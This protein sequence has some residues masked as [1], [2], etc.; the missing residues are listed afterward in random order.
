MQMHACVR[1]QNSWKKQGRGSDGVRKMLNRSWESSRNLENRQ[2]EKCSSVPLFPQQGHR[3]KTERISGVTYRE[4]LFVGLHCT[5]MCM[6]SCISLR[7]FWRPNVRFPPCLK[8]LTSDGKWS[9]CKVKQA[10]G[11]NSSAHSSSPA[12]QTGSD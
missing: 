12:N 2:R 8:P 7:P 5:R 9:R 11:F 4:H 6:C 10:S 3:G 1:K